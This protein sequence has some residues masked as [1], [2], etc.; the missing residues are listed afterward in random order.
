MTWIL[1]CPI[2]NSQYNW[3]TEKLFLMSILTLDVHVFA[4]LPQLFF[5]FLKR[6][7]NESAGTGTVEKFTYYMYSAVDLYNSAVI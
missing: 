2:K 1:A 7:L 5:V 3:A 4:S 6:R